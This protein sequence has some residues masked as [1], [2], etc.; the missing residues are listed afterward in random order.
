MMA[1]KISRLNRKISLKSEGDT[2]SRKEGPAI[3]P[4]IKKINTE[5]N[6]TFLERIIVMATANPITPKADKSACSNIILSRD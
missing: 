6:L 3:I 5:G 4:I 2:R 1:T